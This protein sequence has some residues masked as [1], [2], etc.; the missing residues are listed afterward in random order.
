MNLNET[1]EWWID[2]SALPELIWARLKIKEDGKCEILDIDNKTHYFK[3]QKEARLFL[4]EDEYGSLTSLIKEGEL[5]SSTQ[6][7]EK[8]G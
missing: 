7:P 2:T 1:I 5:P 3:N 8:F 6:P 4:L